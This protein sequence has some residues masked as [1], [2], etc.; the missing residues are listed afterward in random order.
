VVSIWPRLGA[1]LLVAAIA[2]V[3]GCSSPPL[4]DPGNPAP[5]PS[6][7]GPRLIVTT[8]SG[9]PALM[10]G[11]L[12]SQNPH[13]STELAPPDPDG[14]LVCRFSGLNTEHD[15][16]LHRLAT[17]R[18]TAGQGSHLAVLLSQLPAGLRGAQS[19]PAD[20]GTADIVVLD[21]RHQASAMIQVGL[22]GCDI[23]T[24]GWFGRIVDPG[25]KAALKT[26]V[27]APPPLRP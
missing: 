8:A 27:G 11:Q 15:H 16:R 12:I 3:I 23:V 22:S 21:Y 1:C 19:C 5:S 4:G 24:N 6:S 25:L 18:I 7:E 14:G 13:S 10:H 9:C 26:L 2:G 17:A 20:D